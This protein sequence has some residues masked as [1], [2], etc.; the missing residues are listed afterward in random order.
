[1]FSTQ[2]EEDSSSLT[3]YKNDLEYLDDHFQVMQGFTKYFFPSY[4][5]F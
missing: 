1:M 4:V 3:P 2:V 5:G